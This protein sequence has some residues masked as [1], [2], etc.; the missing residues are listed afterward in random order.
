[1]RNSPQIANK[2]HRKGCENTHDK[3]LTDKELR[4]LLNVSYVTHQEG[5]NQE[6]RKA[7]NEAKN[8]TILYHPVDCMGYIV[9]HLLESYIHLQS[10]NR[11]RGEMS[12]IC[13]YLPGKKL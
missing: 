2:N 10:L 11:I 3:R 12:R 4:V 8:N 7:D 5:S 13:N 1:M 6:N 9:G